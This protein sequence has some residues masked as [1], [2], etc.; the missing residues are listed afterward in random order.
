MLMKTETMQS[1]K[2][3]EDNG[4]EN[5]ANVFDGK[6]IKSDDDDEN[7]ANAIHGKERK[8]MMTMKIK[9]MKS[10]EKKEIM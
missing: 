10:M 6:E 4:D 1:P 2:K 8:K 9:L 7:R 3:K 5:I